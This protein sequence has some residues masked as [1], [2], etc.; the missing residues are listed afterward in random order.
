MSPATGW[1]NRRVIRAAA[2]LAGALVFLVGLRA[3]GRSYSMTRWPI[4]PGRVLTSS[5]TP[6]E[7][8]PIEARIT[9]EFILGGRVY[10]GVMPEIRPTR[11]AAESVA[12][13]YP[14]GREI[15]VG[16]DPG[17]L[18]QSVLHPRI[19][20]WS[21]LVTVLGALLVAAGAWPRKNPT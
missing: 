15:A 13:S 19:N 4:T 14:P 3:F 1:S 7:K 16:Y 12:A 8:G 9:Y 10:R 18:T 20:W 17:N 5:V 2:I 11:E 21:L 6:G